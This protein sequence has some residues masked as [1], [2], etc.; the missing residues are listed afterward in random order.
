MK[1][2]L[3]IEMLYGKRN[4]QKLYLI[5]VVIEERYQIKTSYN[6]NQKKN[7]STLVAHLEH[8]RKAGIF[9]NFHFK[10]LSNKIK[11]NHNPIYVNPLHLGTEFHHIHFSLVLGT[12]VSWTSITK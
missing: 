1:P 7:I 4:K 12:V 6:K 3:A 5:S 2:N 11:E 9:E 8:S 10:D